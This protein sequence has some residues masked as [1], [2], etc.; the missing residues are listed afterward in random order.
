MGH[1]TTMQVFIGLLVIVLSV[2]VV[3]SAPVG[4]GNETGSAFRIWWSMFVESMSRLINSRPPMEHSIAT[5]A[6][7][8]VATES[9]FPVED[10][11]GLDFSFPDIVSD[12]FL[13]PT[14]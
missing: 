5:S 1:C 3:L 12:F 8:P 7:S 13:F 10:V 6:P 2:E 9:Q 4:D 11:V 14:D